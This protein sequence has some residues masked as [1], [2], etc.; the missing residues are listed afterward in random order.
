MQL[1][2]IELKILGI[3]EITHEIN[4]AREDIYNYWKINIL[5]TIQN[6]NGLN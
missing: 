2:G 6:Y 4:Q 1:S 5:K 3:R